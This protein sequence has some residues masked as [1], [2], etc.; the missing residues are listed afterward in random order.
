[1]PTH[2]YCG[3]TNK[4][5]RPAPITPNLALTKEDPLASSHLRTEPVLA[6]DVQAG[7]VLVHDG[8]QVTVTAIAGSYFHD[9]GRGGI[10]AG[11]SIACDTGTGARWFLFRRASELLCRV[12]RAS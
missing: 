10:V 4:W 9:E 12:R 5:A 1:M 6:V 3:Q 8:V 2:P 7:D 11:L